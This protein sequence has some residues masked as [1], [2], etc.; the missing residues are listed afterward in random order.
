MNMSTMKTFGGFRVVIATA[1]VG[2]I[3]GS[4]AALPAAA[5]GFDAPQITVKYGDLNLANSQGVATL[6]SR[7]QAAAK[8][9]CWQFEGP[10]IQTT[11][12]RNACVDKA[13]TGAVT[14]VNNSA[15]SA[16]YGEKTGKAMP[17]RVAS[18]QH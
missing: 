15:L 16:R 4:F 14:K 17:T 9:V 6:Y 11:V 1:I 7:I 13:I 10:G 2:V 5:D 3:S 12:Q 8:N 18:L